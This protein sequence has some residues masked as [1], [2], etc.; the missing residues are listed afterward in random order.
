MS[1]SVLTAGEHAGV[2]LG[3]EGREDRDDGEGDGGVGAHS[4][5]EDGVL[6]ASGREQ[7]FKML[8]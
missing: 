6:A 5:G 1:D 4:E 3:R 7:T 8:P 2:G